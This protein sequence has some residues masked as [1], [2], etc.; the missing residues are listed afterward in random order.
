[1]LGLQLFHVIKRDPGYFWIAAIASS[2]AGLVDAYAFNCVDQLDHHWAMA[3]N[4]V[5]FVWWEICFSWSG[6]CFEICKLNSQVK[7]SYNRI[8]YLCVGFIWVGW[9]CY[10]ALHCRGHNAVMACCTKVFLY[11][12]TMI[13]CRQWSPEEEIWIKFDELYGILVIQQR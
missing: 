2:H 9:H 10:S 12:K 1:M 13:T 4:K 3:N 5:V 7:M 6:V 8:T 11:S